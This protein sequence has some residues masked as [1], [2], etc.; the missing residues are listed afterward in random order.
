MTPAEAARILALPEDATSVAATARYRELAKIAHPDAGGTSGLWEQ[1]SE[2]HRV[3]TNVRP[4]AAAVE[5]VTARGA[6]VP[7]PAALVT[8]LIL[9]A[10]WAGAR[11]VVP[12]GSWKLSALVAVALA[13][14]VRHQMRPRRR[15]AP[16]PRSSSTAVA[17]R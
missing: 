2:A 11:V 1:V 15:S 14:Y 12:G 16:A 4:T 13:G 8:L 7:S 6:W 5:P 10:A 3:L 9:A 17:R